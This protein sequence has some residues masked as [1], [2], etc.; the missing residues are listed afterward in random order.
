MGKSL[1]SDGVLGVYQVY[2]VMN[3]DLLSTHSVISSKNQIFLGCLCIPLEELLS[4]SFDFRFFWQ[5]VP[6]YTHDSGP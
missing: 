1:I 4:I 5:G 6:C 3:H 2:V